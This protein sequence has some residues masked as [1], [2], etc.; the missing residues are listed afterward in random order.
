MTKY[1]PKQK[2]ISDDNI[3]LRCPIRGRCCHFHTYINGFQVETDEACSFLKD[4]G[5][6][7]IYKERR[8]NPYCLSI[9]E[10]KKQGT[11][12]PECLYIKNDS[13]YLNRTDRRIPRESIIISIEKKERENNGK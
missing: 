7:S 3:C 6:C 4:N 1:Q 9:E 13:K 11:L 5:L 2:K 12:L 8:K 10:M